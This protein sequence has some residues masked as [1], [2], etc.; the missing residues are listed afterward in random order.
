MMFGT[1][2]LRGKRKRSGSIHRVAQENKSTID[3]AVQAA[4]EPL[5]KRVLLAATASLVKIDT[6]TQGNWT[7]V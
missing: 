3:R 4:I 6:T 1:E 2:A 7:G 5:E